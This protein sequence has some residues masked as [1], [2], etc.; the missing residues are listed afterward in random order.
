M[1]MIVR[2]C[3]CVLEQVKGGVRSM[4]EW[5]SKKKLKYNKMYVK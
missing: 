2:I 4:R 3:V 5:E 1:P